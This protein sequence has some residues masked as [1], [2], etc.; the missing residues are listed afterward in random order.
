[1]E[2][3]FYVAQTKHKEQDLCMYLEFLLNELAKSNRI[4]FQSLPMKSKNFLFEH[5]VL[6]IIVNLFKKCFQ[7]FVF[8]PEN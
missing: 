6:A 3:E 4:L 8:S 7:R 5:S 2:I 1:M